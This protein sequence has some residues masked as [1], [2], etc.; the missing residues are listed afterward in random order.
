MAWAEKRQI[1]AD[2]KIEIMTHRMQTLKNEISEV[3]HQCEE[4]QNSV[5]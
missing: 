3:R 1:K 4:I 5:S 2:E